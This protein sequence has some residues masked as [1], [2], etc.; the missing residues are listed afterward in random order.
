MLGLLSTCALLLSSSALALPAV[1]R[2]NANYPYP[3]PP[4]APGCTDKSTNLTAWTVGDFDFHSSYTFTTPAHQNSWGYVNFTLTNPAVDYIPVCSA[5]SNQLS[6]FFYGTFVYECT[7]PSTAGKATFT[8][9]RPS[10]QLQINQTWS[11]ADEGSRF[12]AI[13]GVNLNLTCD[14]TTW[15]NPNWTVGQIYSTRTVTCGKVTL[16][17]PIEEMSAVL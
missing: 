3:V 13:G 5:A 1:P 6:D 10:G 2:A 11:C 8:Y 7:V 16:P 15:Q 12:T 9:S 14:D 17:A 4:T